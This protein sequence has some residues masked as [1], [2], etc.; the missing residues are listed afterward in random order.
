MKEFCGGDVLRA[1]EEEAIF[2]LFSEREDLY[3]GQSLFTFA[4]FGLTNLIRRLPQS[5]SPR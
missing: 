1:L 5:S 4:T 3:S 2:S